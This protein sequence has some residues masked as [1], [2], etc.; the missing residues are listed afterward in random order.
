[1]S[2]DKETLLQEV[3]GLPMNEDSPVFCA[4][5]E[6]QA[7]AMAVALNEEG[8]FSWKEWADVLGDVIAQD[9]GK[10]PAED[11]FHLWLDA[12]ER[13]IKMKAAASDK[14]ISVRRAE[15]EHAVATTPHGKPIVLNSNGT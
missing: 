15:W 12:L 11:Y 13:I 2:V 9:T 3:P 14:E 5:W 7:F 10:T 1:M 8:L 6:A 4:P